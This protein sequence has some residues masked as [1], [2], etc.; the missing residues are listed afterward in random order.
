VVQA[1]SIAFTD[2]ELNPSGQTLH[3]RSTYRLRNCGLVLL[4]LFLLAQY[5]EVLQVLMVAHTEL[6]GVRSDCGFRLGWLMYWLLPQGVRVRQ[7]AFSL[8]FRLRPLLWYWVALHLERASRRFPLA[9]HQYWALPTTMPRGFWKVEARCA[10]LPFEDLPSVL[11]SQQTAH[12][13]CAPDQP[14]SPELPQQPQ[15]L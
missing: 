7:S 2:A 13:A 12:W 3:S 10:V 11:P 15:V 9:F 6:P 5:V 14:L 4:A 1:H 8:Y